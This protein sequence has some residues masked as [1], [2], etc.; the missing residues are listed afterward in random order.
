MASTSEF[1]IIEYGTK[2]KI[3]IYVLGSINADIVVYSDRFPDPGETL[4]GSDFLLNQGGKGANQAIAARKAGV[5]TEFLGRVGDDY[6]GEVVLSELKKA[7]IFPNVTI[8]KETFTG[9]AIINVNKK[10]ENKI[11][12][13]HGANGKVGNR[14]I[15]YLNNH[16]KKEDVLLIQGEIAPKVLEEA[17][18]NASE[19]GA[20]VIFDPAPV[21]NELK[22]IV[23]YAT[24]VTPNEVEIRSLTG[25]SGEE[26]VKRLFSLGA[27]NV[28]VKLGERGVYYYGEQGEIAL[29]AFK[30]QSVDTTGA[31]DT[32]NGAF[33]AAVSEGMALKDALV[34]AEA[35]AAISV[36]RK[37]AS[38]SSPYKKEILEFLNSHSL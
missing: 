22:S 11:I 38:V 23:R 20:S 10:G 27:K 19:K 14:E 4:E 18:K 2:E 17:A 35:A 33:A 21:N 9:V 7:G 37:G 3:V 36:T 12:I 30:V 8:E 1:L 28:I 24:F 5:N 31:G 16:L 29:P 25:F 32:F 15:S 6:F 13:I 26:G 34:F